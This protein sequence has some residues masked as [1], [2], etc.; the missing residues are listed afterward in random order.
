M[1]RIVFNFRSDGG[2]SLDCETLAFCVSKIWTDIS[3]EGVK[4]LNS[5]RNMIFPMGQL[6]AGLFIN[7]DN[8]TA[9]SK[10]RCLNAFDA[11]NETPLLENME[12]I[13]IAE[14]YIRFKLFMKGDLSH[15]YNTKY[16]TVSLNF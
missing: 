14:N 2:Y 6:S 10:D 8:E 4:A 15:T 11:S 9:S 5:Y 3:N 13:I 16:S 12:L 7:L 1:F